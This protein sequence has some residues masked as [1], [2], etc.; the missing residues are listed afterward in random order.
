MRY[1]L[2][3]ENIEQYF[4]KIIISEEVKERKPSLKIYLKAFESIPKE[5]YEKIIFVS[6]ELLED[7]IPAK[8]LGIKTVWFEQ[9]INNKWKKKE[10]VL[11]EADYKINKIEEIIK[12]VK[13]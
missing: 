12:I 4:K 9:N 10:E 6:D 3:R 8:L 11:I 7:L 5:E 1:I 13:I 2:K